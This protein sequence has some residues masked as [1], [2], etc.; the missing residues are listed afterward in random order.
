MQPGQFG[1]ECAKGQPCKYPGLSCE[2][3]TCQ[4]TTPGD[5]CSATGVCGSAS[6]SSSIVLRNCNVAADV[7]SSDL[8]PLNSDTDCWLQCQLKAQ[9]QAATDYY[10]SFVPK[11]G[12]DAGCY[13]HHNMLT[14]DQPER[15]SGVS[16]RAWGAY[17]PIFEASACD[18]PVFSSCNVANVSSTPL[19]GAEQAAACWEACEQKA[20]GTKDY[21]CTYVAGEDSPGCYYHHNQ[22]IQLSTSSPDIQ[23][24]KDAVTRAWGAYLPI[25]QG[26]ICG[27]QTP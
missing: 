7:A 24:Q 2:E 15:N 6:P 19:Q 27:T 10:C 23:I 12:I 8:G 21:Y 17:V 16:I 11:G 13:Y 20:A 1:G 22:P 18:S 5:A 26:S 3:G 25:F 9:A 4:C 14:K